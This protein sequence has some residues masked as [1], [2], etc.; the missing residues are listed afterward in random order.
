MLYKYLAT[1]DNA[2]HNMSEYIKDDF[3]IS[4]TKYPSEPSCL[5]TYRQYFAEVEAEAAK[6]VTFSE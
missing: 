3:I 6:L 1:M 2:F 4:N 5:A